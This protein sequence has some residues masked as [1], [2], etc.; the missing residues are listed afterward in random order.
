V[1]IDTLTYSAVTVQY[2]PIDAESLGVDPTRFPPD[3]KMPLYHIGDTLIVHHTQSITL[4][5][6][7]PAGSLI[8]CGRTHVSW[9]TLVDNTGAAVPS[10]GRFTL[11]GE[12]GTVLFADPLDLSEFVQPLKLYHTIADRSVITDL[13]ISGIITFSK[14]LKHNYPQGSL[15]SSAMQLQTLQAD[16]STVFSQQAWLNT[17]K[18]TRDGNPIMAQYNYAQFPPLVTNHHATRQRYAL[19]W[20][21]NTQFDCVGESMGYVGSGDKNNNFSPL[22]LL[23]GGSLFTL[24]TLGMGS[25]WNAGNVLRIDTIQVAEH[26][27]WCLMSINPSDPGGTDKFEIRILGDQNA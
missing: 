11:N 1:L 6:P 15:V 18:S 22:N 23:T 7:L 9:V 4:A 2:R 5:N 19:L 8:N 26:S 10:D 24:Y 13:D 3:G 14:L 21:N 27:I 20:K 16:W 12:Y 25:L 17:W